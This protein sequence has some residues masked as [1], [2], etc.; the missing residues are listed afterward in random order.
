MTTTTSPFSNAFASFSPEAMAGFFPQSDA[1]GTLTRG[2]MEA[3]TASTRAT[4]KGMQEAGQTMMSQ[5]K[6]RMTLS[7]ETGKK[8]SEAASL[9]EAMSIQASFMKT[10]FEAN[11]KGFSEITELY[12]ETMREA[13]APLAKQAKKSAKKTKSA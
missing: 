8:L 2:A 6:E 13:F 12:S 10:A 1:M 11:M 7:V 4:V 9:E 3:S 5:M